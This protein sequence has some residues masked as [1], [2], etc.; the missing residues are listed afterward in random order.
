MVTSIF[1]LFPVILNSYDL[2]SHQIGFD[3]LTQRDARRDN[4]CIAIFNQP[5]LPRDL[6]A[7]GEGAPPFMLVIEM[8]RSLIMISPNHIKCLTRF[9]NFFAIQNARGNSN[10]IC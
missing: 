1:H 6:R 8:T 5:F 7:E 2:R 10:I 9:S 4:H 3:T